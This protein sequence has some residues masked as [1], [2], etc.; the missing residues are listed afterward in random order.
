MSI[1]RVRDFTIQAYSDCNPWGSQTARS[2]DFKADD[3]VCVEVWTDIMNESL[4]PGAE[5]QGQYNSFQ[6]SSIGEFFERFERLA[7]CDLEIRPAREGSVA[8]YISERNNDAQALYD[9]Q[10]M[11]VNSSLADECGFESN[12]ELRLWWD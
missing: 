10:S 6:A 11:C 3:T 12:G 2:L 8:C 5:H 4:H 1:H 9:L 7:K